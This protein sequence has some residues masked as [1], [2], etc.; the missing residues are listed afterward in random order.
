MCGRFAQFSKGTRE[1]FEVIINDL[2]EGL[3]FRYNIPPTTKVKTII[4]EDQRRLLLMRWGLKTEW[5]KNLKYNIY[6]VRA[7]TIRN[8]PG[9]HKMLQHSRCIVPVEGFYEW[10]ESE[11]GDEPYYIYPATDYPFAIAGLWANYRNEAGEEIYSCSLISTE[12]NS[13]MTNIK[14]RMPVL[15]EKKYWNEWLAKDNTDHEKLLARLVPYPDELMQYHPVS[16]AVNSARNES[17][18]LIEK[19]VNSGP[20]GDQNE[21]LFK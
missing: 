12:P 17:P 10:K 9:Y 18:K 21:Y 8:K 15:L 1:Q 11:T 4:E 6:L 3:P 14:D 16:K 2:P 5:T 13:L 7:D 19:I 20:I